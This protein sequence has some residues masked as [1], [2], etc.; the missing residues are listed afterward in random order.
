MKILLSLL[1]AT[2]S[3]S[4]FAIDFMTG[5][6]RHG[7]SSSVHWHG[8]SVETNEAG[9]SKLYLVSLAYRQLTEHKFY[10]QFDKFGLGDKHKHY[11]MLVVMQ[12]HDFAKFYVYR[13]DPKDITTKKV[14]AAEVSNGIPDRYVA[15]GWGFKQGDNIYLLSDSGFVKHFYLHEQDGNKMLGIRGGKRHGEGTAYMWQANLKQVFS[16]LVAD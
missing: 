14:D 11:R 9:E 16:T 8:K 5:D 1:V 13:P 4:A 7:R 15:S 6:A 2:W 10:L 3:L 12:G